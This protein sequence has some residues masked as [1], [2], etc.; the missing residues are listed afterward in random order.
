MI[1]KRDRKIIEFIE[2]QKFITIRQ[3]ADIFFTKNE[4]RYDGA[5]FR[6]KAIEKTGNYIKH[7]FNAET[8]EKIYVPLDSKDKKI[9]KHRLLLV[10]YIAALTRMGAEVI[11]AQTT[12]KF[13]DY[14]PDALIIF[15]YESRIYYQLLEI[16]LRH[17]F[18]DVNRFKLVTGIIQKAFKGVLP[19]LVIIQ[20]TKKDYEKTNTTLLKIAQLDTKLNNVHKVI[21]IANREKVINR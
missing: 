14:E 5:R 20:D 7:I 21:E 10:D 2:Q 3:C 8:K 18:V 11:R 17:D 16:E 6:L 13:G 15:K 4:S 19:I 12:P 9:K 1:T